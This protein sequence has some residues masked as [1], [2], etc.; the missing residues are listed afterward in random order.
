MVSWDR[1]TKVRSG[2]DLILLLGLSPRDRLHCLL[3]SYLSGPNSPN[4]VTG[5]SKKK[6]VSTAEGTGGTLKENGAFHSCSKVLC[7]FLLL[8]SWAS[9]HDTQEIKFSVNFSSSHSWLS[10]LFSSSAYRVAQ[11]EP[12]PQL[13]S[14][15]SASTWWWRFT[16]LPLG[17]SSG[18]SQK[19]YLGKLQG[20]SI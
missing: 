9:V 17:E 1:F 15:G 13:A 19:Q 6:K 5:T 18:S 2:I 16:Y 3:I 10:G 20:F 14:G 11:W 12:Q 8:G 7:F 4:C